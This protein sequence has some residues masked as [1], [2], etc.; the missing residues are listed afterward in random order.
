[1]L[2][3]F[4]GRVRVGQDDGGS[5][6]LRTD[7][8]KLVVHALLQFDLLHVD[9]MIGIRGDLLVVVDLPFGLPCRRISSSTAGSASFRRASTCALLSFALICAE[10]IRS[11]TVK[12]ISFSIMFK[13]LVVY[14]SFERRCKGSV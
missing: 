10:Y 13:F 7:E 11:I 12:S 8:L 14:L 1:M 9:S 6:Q 5:F 3:G 2:D 4:G